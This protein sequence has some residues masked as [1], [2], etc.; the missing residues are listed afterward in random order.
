VAT[1]NDVSDIVSSHT[2]VMYVT[3]GLHHQLSTSVCLSCPS[4]QH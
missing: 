3:T 2:D 1:Q 4:L